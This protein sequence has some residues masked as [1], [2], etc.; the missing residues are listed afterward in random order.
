MLRFTKQVDYALMAMQYI[1]AHEADG[2]VGVR[3]IADGLGIPAE[4]LA[5]V[6]QRLARRGLVTSQAG[7]RGGYRLAQAPAAVS[8]GAV[9]RAVDGPIGIVQCLDHRS[10]CPQTARCTLRR[11]ARRIQSAVA[12]VLD[13]MTLAE[14]AG[15]AREPG[16][17][18]TSGAAVPGRT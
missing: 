8:V 1:G 4:Q 2:A 7:P 12:A 17:P 15:E 14:L 11:P 13:T 18:A 6:L 9:V 16:A 5:K 10:V 3:R